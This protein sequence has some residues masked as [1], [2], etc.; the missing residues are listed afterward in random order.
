LPVILD[1]FEFIFGAIGEVIKQLTP[2]ITFAFN[3]AKAVISAALVF[4]QGLIQNIGYLIKGNWSAIWDNMLITMQNLWDNSIKPF[5]NTLP[6]FFTSIGADMIA[7]AIKGILANADAVF[8]T[9]KEKVFGPAIDAIK[10][11]LG[12]HSPSKVFARI[13]FDIV[14]GVQIGVWKQADYLIEDMR[15]V[16]MQAAQAF[17]VASQAA[18]VQY[19]ATVVP[20]GDDYKYEGQVSNT[21]SMPTPVDD[22]LDQHSRRHDVEQPTYRPQ[23]ATINLDG[24]RLSDLMLNR[25]G[26]VFQS[27]ARRFAGR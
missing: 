20:V 10:N 26:Y 3:A 19:Q 5:L 13:G 24:H 14:R 7:G 18:A 4:I 17:S 1:T 9:L 15:A 27:T 2:I 12:I 16:A 23:P 8:E 25:Y 11:F 6:A 22:G 21:P